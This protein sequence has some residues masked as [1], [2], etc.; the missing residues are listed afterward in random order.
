MALTPTIITPQGRVLAVAELAATSAIDVTQARA[1]ALINFPAE[2]VVATQARVLA[3]VRD[4]AN[5]MQITQARVI[6]VA[7]GRFERP[8]MRAWTF[9]LDGHDFYVLQTINETMV[10]D[11]S[12]GRWHIWG[13]GSDVLWRAHTGITWQRALPAATLY[14]SNIVAGDDTLGV[15]YLLDPEG[16]VDEHPDES[17][18]DVPFRRA[19]VGQIAMRGRESVPCWGVEVYGSLGEQLSDDYVSVTLYTSDDQ[20][21]T[22]VNHGSKD[23]SIGD[24]TARLDWL[25]LGQMQAPGRLIMVEDYGALVR[26]DGLE[27][28]DADA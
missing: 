23:V 17:R 28:P 22:Y 13:S 8:R 25:S 19:V 4:P 20:G 27:T 18:D 10:C 21:H 3:V 5:T 12:N 1:L 2:T 6:M 9:T 11:L 24:Y 7:R 14:G 26:I 16:Q 15:L